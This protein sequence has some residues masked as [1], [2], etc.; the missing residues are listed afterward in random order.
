MHSGQIAFRD[1][2][3]L[4]I[5]SPGTEL[6]DL[7]VLFEEDSMS[8]SQIIHIALA[9]DL[10]E[11]AEDAFTQAGAHPSTTGPVTSTTKR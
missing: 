2:H 7:A 4:L 9:E 8:W 6:D 5:L 10:R 3:R 11:V 1:F